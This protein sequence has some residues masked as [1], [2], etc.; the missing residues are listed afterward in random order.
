MVKMSPFDVTLLNGDNL[1]HIWFYNVSFDFGGGGGGG[2]GV[3]GVAGRSCWG[4]F[5]SVFSIL[6]FVLS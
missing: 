4:G 1:L 5:F 6:K 2:V 3:G